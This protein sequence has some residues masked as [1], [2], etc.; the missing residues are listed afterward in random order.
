MESTT[1]NI[2]DDASNWMLIISI[3]IIIIII[4]TFYLDTVLP[5]GIMIWIF[6]IIPIFLTI[7]LREK[8]APFIIIFIIIPLIWVGFALSEP[9]IPLI[10]D[11]F[12]RSMGCIL[13]IFL[14]LSIWFYKEERKQ[15][16]EVLQQARQKLKLLSSITR[17][18]INNQLTILRG[19]LSILNDIP[20]GPIQDEYLQK[21]SAAAERI[22]IMIQ[23][24]NT[25]EEIGV[26]APAWQN[27]QL[28]VDTAAK[29]AALDNIRVVN[30]IPDNIMVFADPL[31]VKVFYN[32]I[33]NGVRY[34][35]KISTIRFFVEGRDGD[36][37]IIC[38]DDGDGVAADEKEKI[39]RRGF[40]KNTGLG[41]FLAREILSITDIT[42]TE[43]GEPGKGARFE[44]LVP[45][46]MYRSTGTS[47]S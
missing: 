33:D 38:E 39:F 1:I 13:F 30:D 4:S 21:A 25:Y 19:F 10:W 45:K 22:S 41:L 36:H 7:W 29:D 44:I 27:V 46:G 43:T 31:I 14:A 37:I 5:L 3:I 40:G 20:P 8:L 24:T 16:E 17:H 26:H 28:L 18:D 35:E 15:R 42:L 6:Y 11:V 34:G 2:H 32:L 47:N 9:A 12:N 23:F